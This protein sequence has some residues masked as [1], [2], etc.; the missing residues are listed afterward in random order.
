VP[1]KI[2]ETV[3]GDT[4]ALEA[5]MLKVALAG[6]PE[7][8]EELVGAICGFITTKCLFVKTISILTNYS[9]QSNVLI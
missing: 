3:L 2:L 6:L 5:T 8:T 9:Y 4:P 7:D 1:F